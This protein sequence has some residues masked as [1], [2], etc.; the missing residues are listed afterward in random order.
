MLL[1]SVSSTIKRAEELLNGIN[2][3]SI[4]TDAPIRMEDHFSGDYLTYYT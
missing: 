3:R 2:D 1:E 4:G